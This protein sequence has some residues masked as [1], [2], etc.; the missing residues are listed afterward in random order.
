MVAIPQ[1]ATW[2]S[3]AG[4]GSIIVYEPMQLGVGLE[5]ERIRIYKTPVQFDC[6]MQG[7]ERISG[8]IALL[9][10]PSYKDPH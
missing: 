7:A 8:V 2:I 10:T 5:C 4:S 9:S 3:A 6:A 1:K